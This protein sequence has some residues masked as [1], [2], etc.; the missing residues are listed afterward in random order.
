MFVSLKAILAHYLPT[1]VFTPDSSLQNIKK[2][3]IFHLQANSLTC[4]KTCSPSPTHNAPLRQT[5]RAMKEENKKGKNK[6]KGLNSRKRAF[7][8]NSGKRKCKSQQRLSTL[9]THLT[10][11]CLSS[12]LGLVFFFPE[13]F[14]GIRLYCLH[15]Y[16]KHFQEG[17]RETTSEILSIDTK[18][19]TYTQICG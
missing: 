9:A 14:S 16:L 4:G 11:L 2:P 8:T 7:Y 1:D 13:L 19:C 5:G 17:C 10:F 12:L 6:N 15:H 3:R 18:F